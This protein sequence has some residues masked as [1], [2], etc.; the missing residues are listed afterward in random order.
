MRSPGSSSGAGSW[1]LR[2]MCWRRRSNARRV[3]ALP[4]LRS[5]TSASAWAIGLAP[6]RHSAGRWRSIRRT[7]RAPGSAWRGSKP[8]TRRCRRLTCARCSTNTRRATTTRSSR[9]SPIARR[10]C[11]GMRSSGRKRRG[12]DRSDSAACSISAAGPGSRARHSR[13]C[14][15]TMAGIDLSPAMIEQARRKNLYRDLLVADLNEALGREQ[16][17]AD[18]IVAADAFVYLA[19]LAPVCRAAA[20][21]LEGGGL[22]AFTTETHDGAGV[23]L[24]EKLRYAHCAEHVRAALEAAGLCVLTLAV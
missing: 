24:S 7:R 21:V 6:A 14:C 11:C 12:D 1:P 20:R 4:G 10:A 9:R 23:V 5:P 18:L 13:R 8:A 22:F 17:P 15:D 2:P 19:D 16:E 3:F